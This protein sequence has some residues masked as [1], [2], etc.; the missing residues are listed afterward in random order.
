MGDITQEELKNRLDYNPLTGVFTW[1]HDKPN[2]K[3]KAGD[4]AG[5]KMNK[6]YIHINLNGKKYLAHRLAWLYTYGVFPSGFIDHINGDRDDNGIVNLRQVTNRENCQNNITVRNGDRLVGAHWSTKMQKWKSSYHYNG[7][8]HNLGV[9]NT[10]QEASKAYI[11]ATQTL[12][13]AQSANP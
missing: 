2:V 4:S 6:G 3:K 1:L 7:K 12:K 5:C 10:A 8:Y 9:F 13:E 11:E